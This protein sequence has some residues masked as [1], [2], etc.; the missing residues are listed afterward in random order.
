MDSY[1]SV[2]FALE[3][4]GYMPSLVLFILPATT[5]PGL[6]LGRGM[7]LFT[8][9]V[10]PILTRNHVKGSSGTRLPIY[11]RHLHTPIK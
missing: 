2:L 10:H 9:L 3:A 11:Q 6:G 1:Y 8:R 5:A 4:M 7:H